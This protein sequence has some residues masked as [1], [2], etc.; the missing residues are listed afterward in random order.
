MPP[1]LNYELR[2]SSPRLKTSI[3]HPRPERPDLAWKEQL[4]DQMYND[5][6]VVCM[7]VMTLGWLSALFSI[8]N[9]YYC[10]CHLYYNFWCYYINTLCV[11]CLNRSQGPT[12][13]QQNLAE[14]WLWQAQDWVVA[15]RGTGLSPS[16]SCSKNK[17]HKWEDQPQG[18]T[19]NEASD[20]C[21]EC[22]TVTQL[23][24]VEKGHKSRIR[25]GLRR[26][27]KPEQG[28]RNYLRLLF[29]HSAG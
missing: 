12:D 21:P 3:C 2:G 22:S 7:Q 13:F 6:N 4:K 19:A 14:P 20:V 5:P 16:R 10:D 24:P 9:S 29:H 8:S 28:S 23:S 25:G 18:S 15:V 17:L 1:E 27:C 11:M 26:S